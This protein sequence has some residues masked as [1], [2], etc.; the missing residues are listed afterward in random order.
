MTYK[1]M[2][3]VSVPQV[4]LGCPSV[5]A[6]PPRFFRAA[7]GSDVD[8]NGRNN[9][10]PQLLGFSQSSRIPYA[11]V[12]DTDVLDHLPLFSRPKAHVSFFSSVPS[13]SRSARGAVVSLRSLCATSPGALQGLS[14]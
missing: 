7:L 10:P 8:A 2:I 11:A 12:E 13:D 4:P 6:C 14:A 5:L 9:T 3:S 1:P